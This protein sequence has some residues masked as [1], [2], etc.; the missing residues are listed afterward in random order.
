M[1][2]RGGTYPEGGSQMICWRLKHIPTGLYFKPSKHRSKS[3]LS[4]KGKVYT[5]KPT[6][7]WA[8]RQYHHPDDVPKHGD[9]PTRPVIETEWIAEKVKT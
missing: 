6:I 1:C 9:C 4:V 2:G 3:N 8:G 5:V 7:K